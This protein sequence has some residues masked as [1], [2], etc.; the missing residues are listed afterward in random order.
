MKK[1]YSVC[2]VC[3]REFA[4]CKSDPV[5]EESKGDAVISCDIFKESNSRLKELLLQVRY[6]LYDNKTHKRENAPHTFADLAREYK[7][8]YPSLKKVVAM[9]R[10]ARGAYI[11]ALV[12]FV[13]I[14]R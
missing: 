2:S 9:T 14:K 4:T 3:D 10:P 11:S 8:Y 1:I 6:K 7:L 12:D 5:F 13:R